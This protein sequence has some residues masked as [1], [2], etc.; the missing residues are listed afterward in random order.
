MLKTFD[1]FFNK[2]VKSH[3]YINTLNDYT[4][5]RKSRGHTRLGQHCHSN[6]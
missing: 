4:Y 5:V 6:Q 1:D 2:E 3:K